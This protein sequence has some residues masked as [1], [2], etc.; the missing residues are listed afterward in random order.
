MADDIADGQVWPQHE[1]FFYIESLVMNKNDRPNWMTSVI[2]KGKDGTEAME[3]ATDWLVNS[4][5]EPAADW[6]IRR[7][8]RL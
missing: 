3:K 7:M 2:F 1:Y 4:R 8:N 5:N 6:C